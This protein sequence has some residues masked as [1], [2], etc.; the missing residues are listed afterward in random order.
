M[1]NSANLKIYEIF[2]S[3]ERKNEPLCVK[4]CQKLAKQLGLKIWTIAINAKLV[5]KPLPLV[6][7]AINSSQIFVCGLTVKYTETK[8]CID[9]IMMA[10]EIGLPG[11]IILLEP[12]VPHNFPGLVF[13]S[14]WPKINMYEDPQELAKWTGPNYDFLVEKIMELL[15]RP[16]PGKEKSELDIMFHEMQSTVDK[17]YEKVWHISNLL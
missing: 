5:D 7:K 10:K 3:C 15:N 14:S 16:V 9:E 17:S 6:K 4:L 1:A 2:L 11:I 13:T 12:T 8:E